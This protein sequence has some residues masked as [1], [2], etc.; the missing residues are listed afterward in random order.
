[1][2]KHPVYID[3]YALSNAEVTLNP[4]SYFRTPFKL[5]KYENNYVDFFK[6]VAH[7]SLPKQHVV[8]SPKELHFGYSKNQKTLSFDVYNNSNTRLCINWIHGIIIA[9]TDKTN[10]NRVLYISNTIKHSFEMYACNYD[11]NTVYYFANRIQ[12]WQ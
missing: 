2:F 5:P 6:D 12:R 3:V 10:C 7:P 8:I 11:T 4:N 1:M 9:V